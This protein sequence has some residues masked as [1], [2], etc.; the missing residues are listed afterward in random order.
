[1]RTVA[2]DSGVH[3]KDL[4]A[5]EQFSIGLE[6]RCTKDRLTVLLCFVA[7]FLILR[8]T[9]TAEDTW[10]PPSK[11]PVEVTTG[12]FLAN[13]SGAAERSETFEAD[14]YLTFRWQDPRLA[15]AGTEPKRFLEDSAIAQ[16]QTMWWPQLEFINT[17]TPRCGQPDTG[18]CS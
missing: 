11:L 8:G 12:F 4:G 18:H 16:L 2:S 9:T 6:V 15:F 5:K 13:L 3:A 1:M 10:L 17:G 14:L 7:I